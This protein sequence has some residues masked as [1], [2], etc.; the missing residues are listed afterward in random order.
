[1]VFAACLVM[2]LLCL[3]RIGDVMMVCNLLLCFCAAACLLYVCMY[4]CM[5]LSITDRFA[6]TESGKYII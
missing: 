4:V 5:Y 2:S 6:Y 1:M 3:K